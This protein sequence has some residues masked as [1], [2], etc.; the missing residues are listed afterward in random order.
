MR[1]TSS[2]RTCPR[3]PAPRATGG[4]KRSAAIADAPPVAE[5]LPGFELVTWYGIFGPARTPAPIVSRLN[6][7]IAKALAD[8]G[9]K[10]RL[11]SQGLEPVTMTPQEVGQYTE[12]DLDRWTR[13]V[14]RAGLKS[15]K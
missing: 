2:P 7:E 13:L 5:S 1:S 12:R 8:A 9:V 14:E 15:G 3:W 4:T 11:G 6:A 10:Q